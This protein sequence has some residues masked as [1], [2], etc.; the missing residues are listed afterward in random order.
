MRAEFLGITNGVNMTINIPCDAVLGLASPPYPNYL[1][2][3]V[4]TL[5]DEGMTDS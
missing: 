1:P 4:Q 2:S 5:Y 3:I